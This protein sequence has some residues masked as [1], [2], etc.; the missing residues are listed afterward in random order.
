MPEKPENQIEQLLRGYADQRRE[1]AGRPLE[2]HP[3]ERQRLQEEVQRTFGQPRRAPHGLNWLALLWPRLAAGLAIF[4]LLLTLVL[5]IPRGTERPLAMAP[6][7]DGEPFVE[8][9]ERVTPV[10]PATP[11]PAE[12][13]K[14]NQQLSK[15]LAEPAVK[16]TAVQTE[17][18]LQADASLRGQTLSESG[19]S[20]AV[21]AERQRVLAANEVALQSAPP[22]YAQNFSQLNDSRSFRQNFNSPPAPR[23]LNS[24]RLEQTGRTVRII[25]DD[26]SI[27]LGEVQPPASPQA[28]EA[29]PA[30]KMKPAASSISGS[31]ATAGSGQSQWHF[32]ASGTNRSLNQLVIFEGSVMAA[33]SQ[34]LQG[35]PRFQFN[36]RAGEVAGELMPPA[37][38]NLLI[39]G[40]ATIGGHELPIQAEPVP[41]P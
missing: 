16:A 41:E 2:L 32:R 20:G 35:E 4:A 24:F 1:T 34:A 31:T 38:T 7:A 6:A 39:Q 10:P 21:L 8:L 17:S 18:R 36:R 37:A 29:A 13:A 33:D 23:V 14:D 25:D 15:A 27:Y 28:A 26:G 40:R 5:L 9:A 11:A 12:P 30:G 22:G 19:T 3:A